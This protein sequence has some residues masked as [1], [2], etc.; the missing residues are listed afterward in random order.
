MVAFCAL[1]VLSSPSCSTYWFSHVH[2]ANSIIQLWHRVY[3]ICHP[4]FSSNCLT[5]TTYQVT[6]YPTLGELKPS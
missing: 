4:H 2:L 3:L 1:P 6:Y 5:N